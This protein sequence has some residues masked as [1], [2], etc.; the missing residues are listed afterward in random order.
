VPHHRESGVPSPAFARRWRGSSPN[1]ACRFPQ[2]KSDEHMRRR[3]KVCR[4][5]D[6]RSRCQLLGPAGYRFSRKAILVAR[7]MG[8]AG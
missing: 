2:A 5:A 7:W 6:M 8:G 3:L 1:A 4:Q